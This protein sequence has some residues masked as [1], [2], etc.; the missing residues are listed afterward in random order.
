MSKYMLTFELNKNNQELIIN[1]SKEGLEFLANTIL[2]LINNTKDG[3]L[4][5]EHLL[6]SSWGGNELS[7]TPIFKDSKLLHQ[8]KIYCYKGDKFQF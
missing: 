7:S 6:S 4:N 2:N 1:G 5:H 3:H 8:V